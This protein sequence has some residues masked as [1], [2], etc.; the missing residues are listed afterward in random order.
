MK[1]ACTLVLV[2]LGLALGMP[3]AARASQTFH[4]RCTFDGT[5]VAYNGH[6]DIEKLAPL[7]AKVVPAKGDYIRLWLKDDLP[8]AKLLPFLVHLRKNR[9]R[10]EIF[11]HGPSIRV[12][13]SQ[14]TS[15]KLRKW[16]EE[17]EEKRQTKR[18]SNKTSGGDVQ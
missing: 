4:V 9:I 3:S 18:T 13:S 7:V 11:G 6:T 5:N 8:L 15:D 1:V 17:Q 2:A 10:A 14:D 16:L 12:P